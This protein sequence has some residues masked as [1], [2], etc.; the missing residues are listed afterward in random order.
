MFA[1]DRRISESSN[2]SVVKDFS[3]RMLRNRSIVRNSS[4]ISGF[5]NGDR[6]GNRTDS[7]VDGGFKVCG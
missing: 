1:G 5:G 3:R 4:A 2:L 6:S 7:G